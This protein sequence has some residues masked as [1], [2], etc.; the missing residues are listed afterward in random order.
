MRSKTCVLQPT[1]PL[2]CYWPRTRSS[3][4]QQSRISQ[5]SKLKPP[6]SAPSPFS[7][8]QPT[9]S[10]GFVGGVVGDRGGEPGSNSPARPAGS[11]PSARHTLGLQQLT[12][13]RGFYYKGGKVLTHRHLSVCMQVCMRTCMSYICVCAH[14]FLH[15]CAYTYS[16]RCVSVDSMP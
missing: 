9:M 7:R 15:G 11:K 8:W 5:R 4:D 14:A 2:L 12:Q 3:N 13:D 6:V 1:L 10:L 16:C